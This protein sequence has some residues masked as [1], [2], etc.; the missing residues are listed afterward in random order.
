MK[1]F[2]LALLLGIPLS[3]ADVIELKW[4]ELSSAVVDRPAT[5]I[6][7][8]DV[9]LRGRITAV[10]ADALQMVIEKAPRT[11]AY[12]PGQAS[13]PGG[14]IREIRLQ[15][16]KGYGRLIGAAGAGAGV[17]LGSLNWAISDSRVNI[18]DGARIAQWAGVTA[19]V[20]VGGYLIGR[21]VDKRDTHI[22]VVG[23]GAGSTGPA[24][25]AATGN[26]SSA[27]RTRSDTHL[28]SQ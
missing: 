15:S 18:S 11:S 9:Q 12:S 26:L 6:L 5:V 27:D 24:P 23:A 22:R 20:V 28:G 3:A 8:N 10:G 25:A 19:G 4:N 7:A 17:A 2:V 1:T 21:L 14:E 16:L 13:I